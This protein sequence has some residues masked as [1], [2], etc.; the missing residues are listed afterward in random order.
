MMIFITLKKLQNI[1]YAV[2]K[3]DIQQT[4]MNLYLVTSFS[5]FVA[6]LLLLVMAKLPPIEKWQGMTLVALGLSITGAIIRS[7]DI[8]I[9]AL[10]LG[11][12]AVIRRYYE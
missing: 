12:V 2:V 11:G 10:F 8:C 3:T 9:I 5:M 1:V 4:K 7:P 6:I